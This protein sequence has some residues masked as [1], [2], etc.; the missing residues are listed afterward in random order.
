L[1]AYE[2]N[3]VLLKPQLACLVIGFLS[4]AKPNFVVNVEKAPPQQLRLVF[5]D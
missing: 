1:L 4:S 2:R 5:I 3:S